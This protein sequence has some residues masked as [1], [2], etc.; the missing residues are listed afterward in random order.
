MY[1]FLGGY[2]C[3]LGCNEI[4]LLARYFGGNYKKLADLEKE[5]EEFWNPAENQMPMWKSSQQM[6]K[7][8]FCCQDWDFLYF[9]FPIVCVFCF[10]WLLWL[11]FNKFLGINPHRI[12][13]QKSN[14]WE[15]L[16]LLDRMLIYFMAECMSKEAK[17]PS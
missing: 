10:W 14:D 4:T 8:Q 17:D 3:H 15:H 2:I 7:A 9:I 16:A 5:T 11:G 13:H 1:F 6:G 12:K